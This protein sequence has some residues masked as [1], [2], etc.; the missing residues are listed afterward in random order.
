[1]SMVVPPF[2]GSFYHVNLVVFTRCYH[3]SGSFYQVLSNSNV[4]LIVFTRFYQ[5]S[6]NIVGCNR[7]YQNTTLI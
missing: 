7:F 4:N 2:N 1:M 6:P 5:N 3:W